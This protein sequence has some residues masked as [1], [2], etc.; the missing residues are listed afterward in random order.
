M[1]RRDPLLFWLSILWR[2]RSFSGDAGGGGVVHRRNGVALLSAFAGY[3]F[4]FLATWIAVLLAAINIGPRTVLFGWLCFLAQLFLLDA[5]RRGRDHLRLLVPLYTLWINFN[6]S[7]LIGYAFFAVFAASGMVGGT[8]GS[9]EATRWTRQ[10]LRK[11][12][13]VGVAS[14]AALFVNPYGRLVALPVYMVMHMRLGMATG[15]EWQNVEFH[16]FYGVLVFVLAVGMLV[17]SLARRRSW[18]LH[19]LLFALLAVY[20]GLSHERFLF[21]MG[22][23]ICPMM[24]VELSGV[25]FAPYDAK[26]ITSRF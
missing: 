13:A 18:P 5:F 23:V 1:A 22:M 17:F 4:G 16:S 26:K 11:L 6:G 8:W 3:N 15:E 9:I 20:V 21:L 19:E 12:F 7:W 10:E 14:V 2:A 25:V 24:T